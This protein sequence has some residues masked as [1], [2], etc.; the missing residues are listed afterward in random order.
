MSRFKWKRGPDDFGGMGRPV[1]LLIPL[2]LALAGPARGEMYRCTGP[3]GRDFFTS[4]AAACPGAQRH[5]PSREVQRLPSGS[6]GNE[7]PQAPG[8]P[9][10]AV[11][12]APSEDAQAAMWKRKRVD[13]EAERRQLSRQIGEL[14]EVVTWCN[15]GGDLVLEDELGVRQKYDCSDANASHR[16]ATTRLAELERYL[17]GGLADECRRA[18][19]LPGW[20]R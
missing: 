3:D 14:E 11:R 8:A 7:S 12:E 5:Q 1:A 6:R 13:A 9:A 15:R 18:G 17:T 4:N 2:A 20:I 16:K 19:C 10:P